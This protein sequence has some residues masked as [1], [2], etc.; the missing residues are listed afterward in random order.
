[1]IIKGK[2]SLRYVAYT[3]LLHTHTRTKYV[4]KKS[5][6]EAIEGLYFKRVSTQPAAV[7]FYSL[8]LKIEKWVKLKNSESIENHGKMNYG[9]K[10]CVNIFKT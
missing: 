5:R 4:K 2:P 8:V 10:V 7:S 9:L 1:M 6:I 3:Y